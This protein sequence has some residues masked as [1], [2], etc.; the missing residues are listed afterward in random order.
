[1]ERKYAFMED[2]WYTENGIRHA[3]V[4]VDPGDGFELQIVTGPRATTAHVTELEPRDD[5]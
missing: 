5:G 3:A 4:V 1:V 2:V